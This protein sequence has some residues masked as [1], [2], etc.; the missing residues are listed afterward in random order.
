MTGGDRSYH[1]NEIG[2]P[3]EEIEDV[4]IANVQEF[5]KQ[6]TCGTE[7]EHEQN[8]PGH[9]IIEP[10]VRSVVAP[11]TMV[12]RQKGHRPPKYL[13]TVCYEVGG[14]EYHQTQALIDFSL[15]SSVTTL[16]IVNNDVLVE[17]IN[18]ATQMRR[19]NYLEVGLRLSTACARSWTARATK[20]LMLSPSRSAA[21]DTIS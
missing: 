6:G 9:T 17:T 18:S 4:K 20:V 12:R 5:E 1:G 10:A 14:K 7:N 16:N 19:F 3:G 13:G 2:S 15:W 21:L 11:V 8:V